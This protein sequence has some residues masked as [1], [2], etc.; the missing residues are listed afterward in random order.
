MKKIVN[1]L[2]LAFVI[3]SCSNSYKVDSKKYTYAKENDNIKVSV[4]IHVFNSNK[5]KINKQIEIFNTSIIDSVKS[6]S[7]RMEKDAESLFKD[8]RKEKDFKQHWKYDLYVTDTIYNLSSDYISILQNKLIYTGGAHPN[9]IIKSYNY[10]LSDNKLLGKDDIF[11]KEGRE[12]LN[13]VIKEEALNL[14]GKDYK[15]FESPSIENADAVNISEDKIII[16]YNHYTIAC[17]AQGIIKV[18]IPKEKLVDYLL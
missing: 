1:L 6:L 15:F 17:Y 9:T 3:C 8:L 4:N 5:K 13:K 16:T 18:E 10:R 7:V 11:K 2:I 12:G 14:L